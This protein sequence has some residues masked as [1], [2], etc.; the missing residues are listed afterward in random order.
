MA[1]GSGDNVQGPPCAVRGEIELILYARSV[2]RTADGE[3]EQWIRSGRYCSLPSQRATI[4]REGTTAQANSRIRSAASI[5]PVPLRPH[6]ACLCRCIHRGP[7]TTVPS[8]LVFPDGAVD[9][10]ALLGRARSAEKPFN[11]FGS[12]ACMLHGSELGLH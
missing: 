1:L 5:R 9:R 3:L 4:Q 8:Y 12:P 7:Q 11:R 6:N 2:C 10:S